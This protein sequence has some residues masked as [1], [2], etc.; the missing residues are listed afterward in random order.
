MAF[1]IKNRSGHYSLFRLIYYV[2]LDFLESENYARVICLGV[3]EINYEKDFTYLSS[4]QDSFILEQLGIYK[5]RVPFHLDILEEYRDSLLKDFNVTSNALYRILMQMPLYIECDINYFNTIDVDFNYKNHE[6]HIVSCNVKLEKDICISNNIY[7]DKPLSN[8]NSF[9]FSLDEMSNIIDYDIYNR[10]LEG[11]IR[12]MYLTGDLTI[13]F[14]NSKIENLISV[15]N[16]EHCVFEY[17]TL[18][19]L[20]FEILMSCDELELNIEKICSNL[21]DGECQF[22]VLSLVFL[23]KPS[24]DVLQYLEDNIFRLKRYYSFIKITY[25]LKSY[26]HDFQNIYVQKEGTIYYKFG[27]DKIEGK[28][29]SNLFN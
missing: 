3:T 6:I 8:E 20:I 14:S 15:Y 25:G 22:N 11:N 13:E 29:L 26:C 5:L 16:M 24:K 1:N 12:S 7:F 23:D 18:N 28:S 9:R 27:W 19:N 4:K 2:L 21:K 10:W 17:D